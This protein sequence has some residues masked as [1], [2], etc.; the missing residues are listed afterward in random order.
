MIVLIMSGGLGKRM[1]SSL[2]KVLHKV[3]DVPMIVHVIKTAL[4]LNPS[5]VYVIIG[6]YKDII[7]EQ[8]KI[9][10]NTH[11]YSM[12]GYIFQETPLG[13]G[14]AIMCSL[15]FISLLNS[16]EKV[17]IL[18]G[19]VP[20][21]SHNTLKQ[22][23]N[24]SNDKILITE[25][26]NPAACGRIVFNDDILTIKQIIEEKECTDEQK[27][28]TFVNCGIYQI[29]AN[30]LLKYIPLISNKNVAKEF[31]LP[32]IVH[33]MNMHNCPISYYK[34]PENNQH[35][36]KNVNTKT[37]LNNLNNTIKQMI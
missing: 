30:N 8:L 15:N 29:S 33:I 24:G 14:H 22:M 20:L 16:N 18:S 9:Y 36:I 25:L 17:I 35:E 21:I 31:Y 7:D 1:E 27:K 3:M 19:D 12:L 10:L 32:D 2:P 26:K 37:D 28:I 5:K 6:K 23:I 34:L 4:S 13:T 11:E